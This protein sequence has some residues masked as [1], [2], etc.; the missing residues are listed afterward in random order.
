MKGNDENEC[1][2][3]EVKGEQREKKGL[4]RQEEGYYRKE[5]TNFDRTEGMVEA[6]SSLFPSISIWNKKIIQK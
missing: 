1:L 6:C 2:E 5:V 3:A 4:N